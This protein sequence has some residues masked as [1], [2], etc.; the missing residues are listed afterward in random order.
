MVENAMSARADKEAADWYARLSHPRVSK[1]DIDDFF[2]WSQNPDHDRAYKRVQALANLARKLS[3]DPVLQAMAEDAANRPRGFWA[4]LAPQRMVKRPSAWIAAGVLMA[5]MATLAITIARQAGPTYETVV[6]ERRVVALSDGSS[7]ELNTDS[8][9]RVRFEKDQRRLYLDRGQAMFAVAHD[10][11]RP[12]IVTAGDTSVRAV[13]TKFEVYRTGAEVRVILAEG[14]VQV[15]EAPHPKAPVTLTAG[16]RLDVP[17]KAAASALPRPRKVD[18][19]AATGWTQGRLTF[20]DAPLASAVAEVNRYSLRK[21]V[22]GQG[23][24]PTQKISGVFDAGDVDAFALGVAEMLDLK[25][26]RR[27]DGAVELTG[28]PPG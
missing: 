17:G 28:A 26:S 24:P 22:L 27:S 11:T 1:T 8:K 19:A 13:G 25:P 21:V 6:G 3:D 5:S 14:K 18:V 7:L 9:V 20:Q 4:T 15:T 2:A 10:P 16:E 12:F 23:A